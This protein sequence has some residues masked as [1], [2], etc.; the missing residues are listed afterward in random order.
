M[1][2][3]QDILSALGCWSQFKPYL[4]AETGA[5]LLHVH[6]P[7]QITPDGRA[8]GCEIDFIP[9]STF[10]VWTTQARKAKACA[11]HHGLRLRLL[12]GEAELYIPAQLADSL[13]REFGAKVKR[14]LSEE[15]KAR[16]K[17]FLAKKSPE[18]ASSR[19]FQGRDGT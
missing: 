11:R 2:H 14:E 4:E 1:S 16:L 19:D 13:L 7:V 15:H 5:L 10:R 17:G 3:P 8:H 12:N 18:E 6:R 9:P